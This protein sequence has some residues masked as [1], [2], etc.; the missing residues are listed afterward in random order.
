MKARFLVFWF[1]TSDPTFRSLA[2]VFAQ[3]VLV[4]KACDTYYTYCTN[5][6]PSSCLPGKCRSTAHNL[7][8]YHST[9]IGTY[10]SNQTYVLQI[11]QEFWR[12]A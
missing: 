7:D 1:P 12:G 8:V 9:E 11:L 3:L 5:H 10:V 6:T 4:A 2:L